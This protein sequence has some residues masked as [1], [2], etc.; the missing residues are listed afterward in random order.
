MFGAK[1]NAN[2][3]SQVRWFRMEVLYEDN[4]CRILVDNHGVMCLF[5]DPNFS[6]DFE[7]CVLAFVRL[8]HS[9]F[10]VSQLHKF[11]SDGSDR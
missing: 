6:Y 4:G 9:L 11:Q 5:G 8:E 10:D 7:Q 2:A 3:T 1:E